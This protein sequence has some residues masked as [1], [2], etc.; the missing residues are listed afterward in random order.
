[1]IHLSFIT[2]NRPEVYINYSINS[3]IKNSTVPVRIN[4][5]CGCEDTSFITTKDKIFNLSTLS[6]ERYS[7]HRGI[8]NQTVNYA[9]ALVDT[10]LVFE[11]DVC[12]AHKWNERLQDII[13]TFE[14]KNAIISLYNG[15]D[16]YNG[17]EKYIIYDQ[18]KVS[19]WCLQGIYY[20]R[21][22]SLKLSSYLLENIN[23]NEIDNTIGI[24]SSTYGYQIYYPKDSIIQHMG[25]V[26]AFPTNPYHYSKTFLGSTEDYFMGA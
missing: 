23:K 24:F 14:N 13:D 7:K 1:M 2:I 15:Y 21:L 9:K 16:E 10:K 19:Y 8:T 22:I 26:S 20:P 12:F 3:C 11:D 6:D 4:V 18:S 17:D 5:Y 25:K